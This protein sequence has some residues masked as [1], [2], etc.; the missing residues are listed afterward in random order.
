[1]KNDNKAMT[2]ND[3]KLYQFLKLKD[4]LKIEDE[5]E[6]MLSIAELMFGEEVTDLP[7]AEFNKKFKELKFL[8]EPPKTVVPPK[9]LTIND[10]KYH[11]DCMLGNITTAQYI[12]YI[13][14]CKTNDLC[15][16]LSVFVVPDGHK[17]N[18]GYDMEEVMNDI[19]MMPVTMV[20][21]ISVFMLRQLQLFI[22]IF[23]KSSEK[24]IR[25]MQLPKKEK[26][27]MI[28]MMDKAVGIVSLESYPVY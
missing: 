11:L 9:K 16:M 10:H 19:N 22:R 7:L 17:Y 8:E 3:V 15:K 20:N 21:S 5:A 13:N 2:W 26:E 28:A 14:H 4:Y 25:R 12:D 24:K 1:M 23:H 6:R 18:D 27:A